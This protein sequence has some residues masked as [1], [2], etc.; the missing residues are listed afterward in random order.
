MP[1]FEF[2]RVGAPDIDY[3]W[4]L[5]RDS[6]QPLT[7]E[8]A[9]WNEAR[10][11]RSI[12]E[13]LREEGASILIEQ[14]NDV[15]WLHVTETRFDIHLGH[16]YLSPERRGQG[17]GSGFLGWMGERARRKG[18]LLSLD[19]IKNSPVR[20]LYERL[21]YRVVRTGGVTLRLELGP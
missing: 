2:R 18:K 9:A 12:E 10:Q 8:L 7:L 5:Y 14:D 1:V 6:M 4:S 13:A 16:L 17:L 19:L 3:C 11:R 15:G 21:G 20:G